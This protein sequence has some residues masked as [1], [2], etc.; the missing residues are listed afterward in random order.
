MNRI[1]LL[2]LA[3]GS[4][5]IAV[6]ARGA[7]IGPA[8]NRVVNR[9]HERS[10]RRHSGDERP[11]EAE[12]RHVPQGGR[13]GTPLAH[14]LSADDSR[15]VGADDQADGSLNSLKIDRPRRATM[16]RY[17]SDHQGLAP[18]EAKPAAFEAERRR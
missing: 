13:E 16:L 8:V 17:L 9:R 3:L 14:L 7:T 10:R 12:V 6:P 5:S 2:L 4:A 11:G 15:G 18:E 1:G